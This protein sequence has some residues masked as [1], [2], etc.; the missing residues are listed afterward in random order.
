M[1]PRIFSGRPIN[2]KRPR[3]TSRCRLIRFSQWEKPSSPQMWCTSRLETCRTPG[4]MVSTPKAAM[5][6]SQMV[7]LPGV[8]PG[9]ALKFLRAALAA[10]RSFTPT[11]RLSAE[12]RQTKRPAKARLA[13]PLRPGDCAGSAQYRGYRIAP[14]RPIG[15]TARWAPARP[16]CYPAA[17]QRH[18]RSG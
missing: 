15:Q 12:C 2:R 9:T 10:G 18:C 4:D 16:G 6:C 11:G 8:L 3:P 17:G 1:P 5:R 7:Q 13:P 14:G